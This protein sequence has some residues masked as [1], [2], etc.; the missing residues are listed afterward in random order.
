MRNAE[1]IR[2]GNRIQTQTAKITLAA[3][4]DFDSLRIG[5]FIDCK[6]NEDRI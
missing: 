3:W 4:F 6:E 5:D 2:Y 1:K